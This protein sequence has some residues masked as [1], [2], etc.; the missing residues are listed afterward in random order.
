M[1][2]F[3]VERFGVESSLPANQTLPEYR[4]QRFTVEY[5]GHV[6]LWTVC[7]NGLQFRSFRTRLAAQRLANTLNG[8]VTS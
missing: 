4:A 6:A 1:T 8:E 2:R 3:D 7:R 5:I